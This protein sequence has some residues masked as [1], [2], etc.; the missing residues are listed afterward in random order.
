V[1]IANTNYFPAIIDHCLVQLYKVY[2]CKSGVMLGVRCY[3]L[4]I[5]FTL[6]LFCIH[7][8]AGDSRERNDFKK[9]ADFVKL[10]FFS[11]DVKFMIHISPYYFLA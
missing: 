10:K 3:T 9:N 8:S 6:R 1:S 5:S 7:S 11:S 4:E 2:H